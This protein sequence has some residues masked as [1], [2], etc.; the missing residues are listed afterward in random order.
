MT[1]IISQMIEFLS[2]FSFGTLVNVASIRLF[3]S[4]DPTRTNFEKL[5]VVAIAQ[6]FFA[7]LLI[8]YFEN[9]GYVKFGIQSASPFILSYALLRIHAL[10]TPNINIKPATSSSSSSTWAGSQKFF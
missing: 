1:E 7:F 4:W 8:R 5:V 10:Y 6:L 3:E 2:G 9:F